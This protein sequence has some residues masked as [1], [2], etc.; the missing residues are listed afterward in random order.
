MKKSRDMKSDLRQL[1]RFTF[2]LW[3]GMTATIHCGFA[4]TDVYNVSVAGKTVG[5]LRV[6][7]IQPKNDIRVQRVESEFKFLFHSG[8]FSSQSSFEGGKLVS[9][10]S[11]HYVNGDLKEKTRTDIKAGHVYEV[12]FSE[13]KDHVT[14]TKRLNYPIHNTVSTL[15]YQEPGEM[16][17]VY[18][19]RFGQMCSVKKLS[20]QR[21]QVTLPDGKQ[22]LYSYR[23]GR[24]TEVEA[25]LAGF[26]LRIVLNENR[27]N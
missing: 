2:A 25:D 16:R 11:T 1:S 15:F 13:K 10:V 21:Y 14:Q 26:K 3:V 4:Q 12:L 17:E 19:E 20:E 9:S 23:S 7:R 22:N 8:K 6:Y 27:A 18:S 5:S 24:C